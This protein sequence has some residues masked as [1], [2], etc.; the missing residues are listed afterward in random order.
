MFLIKGQE[1]K[2]KCLN[3]SKV[4][5]SKVNENKYHFTRKSIYVM[6][7]NGE[8]IKKIGFPKE[9]DSILR[10]KMIELWDMFYSDLQLYVVISMR[11]TY[12]LK[13]LLNEETLE[14]GELSLYK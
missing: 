11:A 4:I 13:T 1:R 8:L 9:C 10:E 3:Y 7:K 14:Y 12:D 2:Y 6:S 5:Y